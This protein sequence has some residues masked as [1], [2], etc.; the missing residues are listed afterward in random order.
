VADLAPDADHLR[1]CAVACRG[2]ERL[3]EAAIDATIDCEIAG[4]ERAGLQQF[5]ASLETAFDD[6]LLIFV[7]SFPSFANH[8]V[9]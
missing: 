8:G 2:H 9:P 3:V 7:D 6:R 5:V 4:L 1:E